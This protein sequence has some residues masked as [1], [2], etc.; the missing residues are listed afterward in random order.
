MAYCIVK[1][2]LI[3]NN[4]TFDRHNINFDFYMDNDNRYYN[5]FFNQ[6]LKLFIRINFFNLY[7]KDF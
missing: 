1:K 2:A 7:L 4:F 3:I 5:G 6:C